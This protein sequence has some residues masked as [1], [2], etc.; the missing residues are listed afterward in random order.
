MYGNGRERQNKIMSETTLRDFVPSGPA[1][2]AAWKLAR[3]QLPPSIHNHS[4]RVYLYGSHLMRSGEARAASSPAPF[5]DVT[6]ETI[7]VACMLHDFGTHEGY[8]DNGARFEV[9]GADRAASLLSSSSSPAEA[10]EAWLAVALHTSG[11]IADRLPGLA[12]A[13]RLA[14]LMDF[15]FLPPPSSDAF[16]GQGELMSRLLPRLDVEKDLG[17]AVVRGAMKTPAKAPACSWPR[18]LLRSKMENPEWD[19]V[20]KAF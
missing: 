14:V 20:N 13:L 15:G 18:D 17:D 10:R 2:E 4:F 9:C 11:G 8:D 7:F 19:G 6:D 16:R 1:A 5:V 3:E 12:R